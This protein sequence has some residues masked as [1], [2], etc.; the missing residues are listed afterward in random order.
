[1]D[2]N[3]NKKKYILITCL[4]IGLC[5]LLGVSFYA[6]I[7][8]PSPEDVLV[9]Y[10]SYIN[11]K[12]YE[13]MYELISKE[14][15]ESISK[16][17]FINRN[18]KI[19]EG[20]DTKNL[21]INIKEVND[22][23]GSKSI[24]YE[25][26]METVASN[27][28]FNNRVVLN[29]NSKRYY[30]IEWNSS[31]IFPDL[32]KEDKV[33]VSKIV[34]ERGSIVDRNGEVLAGKGTVASVGLV[35]GKMSENSDSDIKKI[36]EILNV[37][38]NT[39][40]GKLNQSYVKKDSF[41]PIKSIAQNETDMKALLLEIPG[42]MI[43]DVNARVYPLGEMAAHLTGYVQSINGDELKKLEGKNYS[44]NS[45]IG[46]IGLE[47]LLEDRIRG[48]DGRSI[49]IVDKDG[50]NKKTLVEK[51]P[52][53]GENVK[54][55]I[56]AKLQSKLYSKL[57]ND[58]SSTV[59][60][61]PKTGEVLALISTPAY[62]PNEFVRGMQSD[63]WNELNNSEN[64]PMYNRFKGIF[65]P[66]SSFKPL[67][68]AIGLTTGKISH[69]ENFGHSGLKWRKDASWGNYN[70]T[71]LKDYGSQVVMRNALVYSDNI[72]FAKAALK[73]GSETL[74]KELLNLGFS[75][76]VPFE[77]GLTPSQF[78]KD[79]KFDNEIQLADSGYGQGKVL[80]NPVHMASIYSAF[81]NEGSMVK[82]YL[83]YRDKKE[84]EFW[85]KSVFSKEAAD[86]VTKDLIKVVEDPNGT[87]YSG[88]VNG[89]TIAGKTGT[90]E[91]KATKED[92]K[93]TE[94]GWFVAFT[95]DKNSDKQYLALTM[96]EDVKS[97]GGS[98]YVIPIV[99]SVF[100]D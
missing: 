12:D 51:P 82:P 97:R 48:I 98:H 40:K 100:D 69:E 83:E 77:F 5:V 70:V 45:V 68:A 36:S 81:I 15:K 49:S 50:K 53:N 46:K 72:Y 20:I 17:D 92:T 2:K 47:K 27:L 99:K 55:T 18:K 3:V 28:N 39:I 34:G 6:F 66:G 11:S 95:A 80:V 32:T 19:Y 63:R 8:R 61:N 22:N 38:E 84:A 60:M 86:A 64:K 43:S 16:E 62:D 13:K 87:G 31:V 25:T 26:N 52:H 37:D 85:K 33:K 44:E 59:V 24:S 57:K 67:V 78:G 71:T 88:R 96:V 74:S 75:E 54:L 94:L 93:G 10:M 79:N 89:I 41:V 9:K 58:K 14:S 42:V 91:I 1:M 4:V 65:S 23:K 29:K 73:I 30:L 21:K 90:A 56:D 7:K 76:S 35:P